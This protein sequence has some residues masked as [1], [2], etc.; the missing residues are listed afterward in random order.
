ME[1]IVRAVWKKVCGTEA[2]P[3][4]LLDSEDAP[5]DMTQAMQEP[6]VT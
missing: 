3:D 4:N 1:K 6:L 2:I 5:K